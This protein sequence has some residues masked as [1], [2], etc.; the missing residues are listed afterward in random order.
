[1]KQN[2]LIDIEEI[3]HLLDDRIRDLEQ[4]S[5]DIK[6]ALSTIINQ[7]N[8]MCEII[9]GVGYVESDTI[10]DIIDGDMKFTSLFDKILSVDG[11]KDKLVELERELKK[12]KD[13]IVLNVVGKT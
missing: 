9:D 3:L 13:N 10:I 2:E 5:K 12:V 11:N 7:L 8:S 6:S 4:D 1:M